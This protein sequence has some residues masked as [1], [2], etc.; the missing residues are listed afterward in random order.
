M[1]SNEIQLQ[2]EKS[3][4]T[5]RLKEIDE[6]EN[7][8]ELKEYLEILDLSELIEI[9]HIQSCEINMIRK[10]ILEID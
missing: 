7:E 10:S 2:L 8:Q 4:I 1:K 5:L 3:K 9:Y 6:F